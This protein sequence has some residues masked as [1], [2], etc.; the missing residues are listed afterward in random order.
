MRF[1]VAIGSKEFSSDTLDLAIR[2]ARAFDANLSVVCVGQ[3]RRE[4]HEGRSRLAFDSMAKWEFSHPGSEVLLWA[5]ERLTSSEMLGPEA[6]TFHPELL[7]E[8]GSRF[9]YKVPA[10][11]REVDLVLR[12]GEIVS[13]LRSECEAGNYAVTIIGPSA[14][15]RMGHAIIEYLPT[16]VLVARRLDPDRPT[17]LL[18]CVD[19]ST[20]TPKAVR[21]A[22]IIA[23]KNR[24]AVDALTVSKTRRFGSGYRGASERAMEQLRSR[25]IDCA[26]HFLTG[27][28]A[29]TIVE[30]AASNHLI[31]MGSSTRSPIAKFFLGSKPIRV[32][33]SARAPVLVVK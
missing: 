25:S 14:S 33:E 17:R 20:L 21:Y 3:A 32:A 13:E 24:M 11:E 28:P 1:L 8:E 16:S 2:V 12:E 22:A 7:V 27:D 31:V 10:G 18:L 23:E 26:D 15:R 6:G 9:R 29:K 30:F 4:L 5:F 19:D